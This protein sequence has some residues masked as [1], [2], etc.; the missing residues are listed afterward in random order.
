[1]HKN[2]R[3]ILLFIFAT[4]LIPVSV[5]AT[6]ETTPTVTT[7]EQIQV[8][9]PVDIIAQ[10]EPVIPD[11]NMVVTYSLKNQS[12]ITLDE[13]QLL[14]D[15][16]MAEA[17]DQEWSAQYAVACTVLR[18]LD[19]DLFPDTITEIIYQN[20]PVNQFTS[21]YNGRLDKVRY[22]ANDS[23]IKAVQTAI[24]YNDLPTNTYYFTSNGY[25]IDS[26]PY[27]QI[28]NM[29]FSNQISE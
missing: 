15:L 1:M 3:N 16:V 14:A 20:N 19:S 8:E 13:F 9:K 6:D 5:N 18:R 4:S 7:I 25:L 17:E 26:E 11:P 29:Y 28:D 2:L 23:C 21:A 27:I 10:T 22:N 12:S 24:E